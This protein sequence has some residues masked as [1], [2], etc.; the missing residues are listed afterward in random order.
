MKKIIRKIMLWAFG[1]RIK[2]FHYEKFFAD[3]EIAMENYPR[4]SEYVKQ[5]MIIRIAN[6]MYEEGIIKFESEKDFK[7]MGE[8]IRAKIYAFK[9]LT[10]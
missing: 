4:N 8:R 3:S 9:F 5:E 7:L 10:P 6:K 2:V 1:N